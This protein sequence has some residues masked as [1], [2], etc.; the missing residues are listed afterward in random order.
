MT[1]SSGDETLELPGSVAFVCVGT[2]VFLEVWVLSVDPE[3]RGIA[4]GT[5]NVASPAFTAERP[6]IDHGLV[7]N[8]LPTGTAD[9]G[10]GTITDLGGNTLILGVGASPMWALLARVSFSATTPGD[11][12]FSL[13]P[14]ALR[15]ALSGGQPPLDFATDVLLGPAQ[16]VG[17]GVADTFGDFDCDSGVDLND[18]SVLQSCLAGPG[19]TSSSCEA[20]SDGDTDLRDFAAFQIAYDGPRP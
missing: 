18:F 17:M 12:I 19:A 5:V 7:F 9:V 2:Q 14:G 3:S 1:T 20:D 15:F 13:S 6:D 11:A 10:S 8:E 16:V 4:G